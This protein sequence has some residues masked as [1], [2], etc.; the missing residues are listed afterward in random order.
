[1]KPISQGAPFH[2]LHHEEGATLVLTDVVDHHQ[3]AMAESGEGHDLVVLAACVRCRHAGQENFD[4]D[5]VAQHLSVRLEDPLTAE[6]DFDQVNPAD[7]Y[8]STLGSATVDIS[9]LFGGADGAGSSCGGVHRGGAQRRRLDDVGAGDAGWRC[10]SWG[11]SRP[12]W[13]C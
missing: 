5:R 11:T 3:A 2:Q 10:A 7:G 4:G 13:R 6:T 9:V 8:I 1:V 12:R